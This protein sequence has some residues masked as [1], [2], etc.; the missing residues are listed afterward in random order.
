MIEC[1]RC[2]QEVVP[3]II[4]R[5]EQLDR[6]LQSTLYYQWT[7]DEEQLMDVPCRSDQFERLVYI[8][9]LIS[10]LLLSILSNMPP[11]TSL[12]L[13]I[14]R[15]EYCHLNDRL[16]IEEFACTIL[17]VVA[18]DKSNVNNCTPQPM[19]SGCRQFELVLLGECNVPA[20]CGP[21]L[22]HL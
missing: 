17:P 5:N 11:L 21:T 13:Y 19:H 4:H 14:R 6:L 22:F 16:S 1:K 10:D 18:I 9:V 7:E 15:C 12:R 2:G 8:R 20:E 3:L